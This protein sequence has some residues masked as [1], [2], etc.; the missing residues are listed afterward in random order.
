M[1]NKTRVSYLNKMKSNDIFKSD[2]YFLY[3]GGAG[4]TVN[5]YRHSTRHNSADS[6]PS[7]NLVCTSWL[8]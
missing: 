1:V 4:V 6:V 7:S 2:A 3:V 8:L 5:R